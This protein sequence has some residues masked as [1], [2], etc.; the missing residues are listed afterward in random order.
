MASREARSLLPGDLTTEVRKRKWF[1]KAMPRK[2]G[3][4][5][6]IVESR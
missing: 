5:R 3:G 6:E 4:R 1:M 2:R